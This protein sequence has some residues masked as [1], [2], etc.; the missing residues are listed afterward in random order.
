MREA[1]SDLWESDALIL[2][3]PV[4]KP[5]PPRRRCL[6]PN[7]TFQIVYFPFTEVLTR[8]RIKENEIELASPT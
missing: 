4:E 2:M 6:T 7:K 1:F 8:I 3:N 5:N